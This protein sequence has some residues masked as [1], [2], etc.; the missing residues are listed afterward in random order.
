MVERKAGGEEYKKNNKQ[1]TNLPPQHG[2]ISDK[3]ASPL[4]P[5]L[6]S[7]ILFFFS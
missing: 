6:L 4:H 1:K 2:P 7:L 5:P 3:N